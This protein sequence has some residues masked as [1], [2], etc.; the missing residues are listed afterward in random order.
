MKTPDEIKKGLEVCS[1]ALETSN[2]PNCPYYKVSGCADKVLV[3]ARALIQQLEAKDAE[4]DQRIAELEQEL[5][6]VKQERD[7]ALADLDNLN[8]CYICAHVDCWDEEPCFSC[9]HRDFI[10]NFVSHFEWRGI[11]PEN[12]EVQEDVAE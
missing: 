9:I 8:Q 7:A 6:A 5:S 10:D 2:C 1:D 12:T 4:K 11:C 3:D